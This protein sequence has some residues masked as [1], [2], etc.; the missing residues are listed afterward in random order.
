MKKVWPWIFGI[1]ISLFIV[2]LIFS[3]GSDRQA[4]W[5]ARAM[6][7]RPAQVIVADDATIV[8]LPCRLHKGSIETSKV[9]SFYIRKK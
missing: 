4:Y 7:A 8:R 2:A 9:C 6:E 5:V 3:G 1:A